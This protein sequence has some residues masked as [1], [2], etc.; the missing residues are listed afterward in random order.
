MF[1]V[2]K[3]KYTLPVAAALH[4]RAEWRVEMDDSTN[5]TFTFGLEERNHLRMYYREIDADTVQSEFFRIRTPH[6]AF[7]FF[8]RYGPWEIVPDE[9]A[10]SKLAGTKA[11]P[12]KWSFVNSARSQLEGAFLEDRIPASVYSQ[13]FDRPLKLELPF[14]GSQHDLR[15]DED[16]DD[17][18]WIVYCEEVAGP[19]VTFPD[20]LD[21]DHE[22][23]V[24]CHDVFDALR[25]SIF[26]A[27]LSSSKWKRCA[28]PDCNQLFESQSKRERLY[29]TPECG[30]LQAVRDYNAR[31]RAA[32]PRRKK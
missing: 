26:L 22:A 10:N 16:Q 19:K 14:V 18:K 20:R 11:R 21:D 13:L 9:K 17:D 3:M 8:R 1:D 32:Q 4:R 23:V 24:H 25:A 27:R 12:V 29:C 5:P 7:G 2:N 31:K 30:H 15:H 28:R 6:D